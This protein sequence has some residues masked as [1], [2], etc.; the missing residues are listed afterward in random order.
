MKL[1]GSSIKRY[2]IKPLVKET[3][4]LFSIYRLSPQPM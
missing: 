3:L 1:L 4:K 2:P